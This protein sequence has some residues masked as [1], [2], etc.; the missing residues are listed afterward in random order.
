MTRLEVA[1]VIIQQ[2]GG[3]RFLAQAGARGMAV[4]KKEYAPYGGVILRV[5]N[6]TVRIV[7]TWE[8]LYKVTFRRTVIQ[9]PIIVEVAGEDIVVDG[10]YADQLTDLFEETTGITAR[11]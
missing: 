8:D 9:S 3:E 6:W 2:L 10:V 7:L 5:P 1:E 4:M 11:S